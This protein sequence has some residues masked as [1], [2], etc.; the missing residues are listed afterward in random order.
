M[1]ARLA[2]ISFMLIAA[3]ATAADNELTDKEKADGW[4]QLFDGKSLDG[5]MTSAGKESKTPVNE[6]ADSL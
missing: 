6:S 5:W 2:L 1:N 3:P 4:L